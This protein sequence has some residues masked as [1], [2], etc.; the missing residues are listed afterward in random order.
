MF[1]EK[2]IQHSLCTEGDK[3]STARVRE[4]EVMESPGRS[5][6]DKERR[7]KGGKSRDE[8][9]E[10]EDYMYWDSISNNVAGNHRLEKKKLP[11][12]G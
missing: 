2:L 3:K 6:P 12:R 5:S 7:R 9:E 1:T 10:E 4:N 8:E 11:V